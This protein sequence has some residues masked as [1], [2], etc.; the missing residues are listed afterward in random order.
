VKRAAEAGLG[1]AFVSRFAVADELAEGRLESFRIAG[2]EPLRRHFLVVRLAGRE[3]TPAEERFLTTLWR[4][5]SKTAAYAAACAA[6]CASFV[7][8]RRAAG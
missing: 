2:R 5:C 8:A 6:P 4:C 7:R 3:P 1:Y